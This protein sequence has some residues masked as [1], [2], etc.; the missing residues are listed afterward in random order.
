MDRCKYKDIR[1][2]LSKTLNCENTVLAEKSSCKCSLRNNFLKNW[3][4]ANLKLAFVTLW[5]VVK[6]GPLK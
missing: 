3:K 1:N 5:L 4:V 6:P 2:S